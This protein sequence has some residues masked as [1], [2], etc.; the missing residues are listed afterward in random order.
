MGGFF[1]FCAVAL[2]CA[3]AA[4][5]PSDA[6]LSDLNRAGSLTSQGQT[7]AAVA[8]L[9]ALSEKEPKPPGL[10]AKLGKAYFKNGKFQPAIRHLGIALE[11]SPDDWESVQLL[12]LSYYSAGNCQRALP[13]LLKLGP[14][15]PKGETDAPYLTG[16][17]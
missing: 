2:L 16:V 17:C 3:N 15:L 11:Q 14:H 1:F 9:D 10:E 8:I 7:D 13:L 6:F 12:A 4:Q 5:Q